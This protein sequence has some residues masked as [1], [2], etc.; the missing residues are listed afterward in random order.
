MISMIRRMPVVNRAISSWFRRCRSSN[1]STD[2]SASR[3]AASTHAWSTAPSLPRSISTL[4]MID[5]NSRA[6]TLRTE[7][8]EALPS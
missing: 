1:S 6:G 4:L 5:S 7:Q 2:T 3:L 8:V